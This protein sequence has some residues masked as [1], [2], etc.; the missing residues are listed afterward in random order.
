MFVRVSLPKNSRQLEKAGSDFPEDLRRAVVA[1][2]QTS[3]PWLNGD[4]TL[5]PAMRPAAGSL[6]A[7]T[8]MRAV[9]MI[10][11]KVSGKKTLQM[12]FV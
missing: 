3:Q 4:G 8:Q 2:V 6:L 9:V 1:M 5:G 7:Q 10:I 11:V 12:P